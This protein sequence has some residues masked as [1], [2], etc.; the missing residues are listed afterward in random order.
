[1]QTSIDPASIARLDQDDPLRSKRDAFVLPRDVIYLDGNSLGPTPKAAL[2]ELKIAAEHEWGEGLIR[3][4]N[5]A[6]W[7]DLPATLGDRI[8]R[9]IGAA[10]GETVVTDTTSI[11]IYKAIHAGLNLRPGRSVLVAE[12]AGFP[13]DLYM[14]VVLCQRKKG[15]PSLLALSMK[16]FEFSTSTSSNVVI[17]YLAFCRPSCM[18]AGP[19]MPSAAARPRRGSPACA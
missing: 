4:W 1:M 19:S 10:P 2:R 11:N 12:G 14:R 17:S 16:R 15:L 8:A 13:T 5:S 7:I 9:L 6:G 3:S 18:S